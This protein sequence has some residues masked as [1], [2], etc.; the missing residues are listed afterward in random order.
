MKTAVLKFNVSDDF[1][2]GN[3]NKCRL[4]VPDDKFEFLDYCIMHCDYDECPLVISDEA[5]KIL[6]G[7]ENA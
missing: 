3:C 4:Y 7:K 6:G 1:E 2:K 5:E